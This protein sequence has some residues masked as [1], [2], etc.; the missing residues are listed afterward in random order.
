[1]ANPFDRI[2]TV[3]VHEQLAMMR[4]LHPSFRCAVEKGLLVCRGSIRPTEV[5]ATYAVRIEYR[6]KEPPEVF[7]ESPALKRRDPERPIPH[8]YPGDRPC[9]Y[10]PGAEEWRSDQHIATT[11]VPWLSEWL[12]YYEV[13]RATDEWLGGGVHPTG[14]Q[15]PRRRERGDYPE[16]A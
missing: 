7:V 5:N 9:L 4:L 3:G 8:T 6:A 11:I 12:F 2:H 10:L 13:W 14:N 16:A 1:M 15:D